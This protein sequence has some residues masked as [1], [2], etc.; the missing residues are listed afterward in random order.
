MGEGQHVHQLFAIAEALYLCVGQR[1]QCPGLTLNLCLER[2]RNPGDP[3]SR[4]WKAAFSWSLLAADATRESSYIT[5]L[6]DRLEALEA[7]LQQVGKISASESPSYA[8]SAPDQSRRRL[9][10]RARPT[11]RPRQLEKRRTALGPS[12]IIQAAQRRCSQQ[13]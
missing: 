1:L 4:M 8:Y 12:G 7:L 2:P 3:Q 11:R 13:R 10:R 5:G 9:H 6:E